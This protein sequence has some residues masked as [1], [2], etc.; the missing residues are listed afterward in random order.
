MHQCDTYPFFD[1]FLNQVLFEN[2]G[3]VV[4]AVF[5]GA[6]KLVSVLA[7][8]YGL[9]FE[10]IVKANV[11]PFNQQVAD[12]ITNAGKIT[13]GS[14][15]VHG[16]KAVMETVPQLNPTLEPWRGDVRLRIENP[17]IFA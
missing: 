13:L 4:H 10:S 17:I 8:P 12:L 9:Q 6:F 16:D 5:R 2:P 11:T 7:S 1:Q 15:K 14:V 3:Q